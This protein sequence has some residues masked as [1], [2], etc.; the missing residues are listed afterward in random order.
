MPI[1]EI[2]L[3]LVLVYFKITFS[4]TE[5]SYKLDIWKNPY[6]EKLKKKQPID[7]EILNSLYM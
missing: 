3:D 5:L 2:L 6:F 7:P 4:Q 1:L